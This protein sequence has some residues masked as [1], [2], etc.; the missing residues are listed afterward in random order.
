MTPSFHLSGA[1]AE[2]FAKC[3]GQEAFGMALTTV[4][5]QRTFPHLLF[6]NHSSSRIF[7]LMVGMASCQSRKSPLCMW[8][9]LRRRRISTVRLD[10]PGSDTPT[11]PKLHSRE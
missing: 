8:L 4:P 10:V 2:P 3:V 11:C 6:A 7:V 5:L 9:G 1:M